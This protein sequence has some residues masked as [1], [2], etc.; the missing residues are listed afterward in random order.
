V[1]EVMKQQED[2]LWLVPELLTEIQEEFLDGM[3]LV[4]QGEN[5]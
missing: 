1:D 5:S 3:F 4:D 2:D